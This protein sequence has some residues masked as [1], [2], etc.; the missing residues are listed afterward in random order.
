LIIIEN[1]GNLTIKE[2]SE[3]I[4]SFRKS[5][6]M[7]YIDCSDD[8]LKSRLKIRIN[9]RLK[10]AGGKFKWFQTS[11][12]SIIELNPKN[13]KFGFESFKKV[14][15]HEV[16]HF[17]QWVEE[18][19]TDHDSRF[20]EICSKIGGSMNPIMAGEKYK[21]CATKDFVDRKYNW[22]YKCSCGSNNYSTVKRVG[23]KRREFGYCPECKTKVKDMEKKI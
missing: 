12:I 15:L 2:H 9:S 20:K 10:V 8:F 7:F 13:L 17:I 5:C 23:I 1:Y 4:S 19:T 14:F 21:E 18:G 6:E 3:L 16:A 11:S 22:H